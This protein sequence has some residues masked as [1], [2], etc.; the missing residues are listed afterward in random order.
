[1]SALLVDVEERAAG[2]GALRSLGIPSR[3]EREDLWPGDLVRLGFWDSGERA[4]VR[5]MT[6]RCRNVLEGHTY[7]GT[8]ETA[9]LFDDIRRGDEVIFGPENVTSIDSRMR[10]ELNGKLMPIL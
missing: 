1:V 2:S 7:V 4:F 3:S 5:V 9:P 6:V 8:I 10:G